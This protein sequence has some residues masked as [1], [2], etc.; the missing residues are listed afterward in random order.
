MVKKPESSPVHS[1]ELLN[2]LIMVGVKDNKNNKQHDDD[3]DDD[4]FHKIDDNDE[5]AA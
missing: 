5:I 1:T 2:D 3:V 4:N